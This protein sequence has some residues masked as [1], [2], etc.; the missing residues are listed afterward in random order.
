M[1]GLRVQNPPPTDVEPLRR[2]SSAGD[3][4]PSAHSDGHHDH[5]EPNHFAIF[6]LLNVALCALGY[7][8]YRLFGAS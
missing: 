8:L 4:P 1:P 3:A 2:R 6:M 7:L 5:P